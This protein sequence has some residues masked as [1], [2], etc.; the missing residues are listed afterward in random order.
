MLRMFAL[1]R[2][3]KRDRENFGP[4][5]PKITI[6]GPLKLKHIIKVKLL[7]I[8]MLQVEPAFK[9]SGR[10]A[11]PKKGERP[12]HGKCFPALRLA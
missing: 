8:P 2:S 12:V 1:R 9:N 4:N 6:L 5:G 7:L 3:R 11:S 10:P